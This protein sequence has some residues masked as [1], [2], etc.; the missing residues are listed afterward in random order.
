MW[1]QPCEKIQVIATSFTCGC[2]IWCATIA[3]KWQLQNQ[4]VGD[5]L[6]PYSSAIA[7]IGSQLPL[8]CAWK[9]KKKNNWAS[10]WLQ[11]F[12]K[13]DCNQELCVLQMETWLCLCACKATWLFGMWLQTWVVSDCKKLKCLIAKS[14][15]LFLWLQKKK[16]KNEPMCNCN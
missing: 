15:G 10:V 16:K 2:N 14:A 9:K 5:C 6:H 1:L 4:N 3:K 12:G 13:R 7:S 8:T 11:L